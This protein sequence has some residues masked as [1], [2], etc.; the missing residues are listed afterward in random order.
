M[1]SNRRI[2]FLKNSIPLESS[3]PNKKSMNNRIDVLAICDGT[4]IL[5]SLQV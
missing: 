2:L 4:I 3:I 5:L 1:I